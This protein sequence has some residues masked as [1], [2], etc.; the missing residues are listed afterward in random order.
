MSLLM[1][2]FYNLENN[3]ENTKRNTER[4]KKVFTMTSG[5]LLTPVQPPKAVNSIY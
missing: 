2:F 5:G 1:Q 4:P 3:Q